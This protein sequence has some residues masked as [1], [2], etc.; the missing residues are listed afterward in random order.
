VIRRFLKDAGFSF[1]GQVVVIVF[2]LASSIII[3]RVLG[4]EQRGV[5]AIV[6]LL[7]MTINAVVA[8]G[9]SATIVHAIA[10]GTW[11][12]SRVMPRVLGIWVYLNLIMLTFGLITLNFHEQLFSG[13]PISLLIFSLALMPASLLHACTGC[14]LA[15]KRAFR[16][17]MYSRVAG[18]PVS[19]LLTIMLVWWLDLSVFGAVTAQLIGIAVS[20][21]L[22]IYWMPKLLCARLM[23]WPEMNPAVLKGSMSFGLKSHIANLS[24]FL[25]YRVDQFLVNG[26][27]GSSAVGIYTVAVNNAERLWLIVGNFA[28][29]LF[30]TASA[31]Q[32]DP[33]AFARFTARLA[34]SMLFVLAIFGALLMLVAEFVIVLLYGED[35]RSAGTLIV[36]LV[37]GIVALGH[38]K[39]LANYVAGQ[40]RPGI[41]AVRGCLALVVNIAANLALIP[42]YGVIGAAVATT[43]SYSLSAFAGYVAFVHVA[44]VR[45]REPLLPPIRD[46]P[47]F[48]GRASRALFGNKAT[49]TVPGSDPTVR[50]PDQQD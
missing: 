13:T 47:G 38:S 29:V 4:P 36:W 7:P 23:F 31:K 40:G 12:D 41:N 25:N 46:L 20:V 16:Y 17:Q 11:E 45:W 48:F 22:D 24:A 18:A 28:Q 21:L 2:A 32:D 3:A 43:I 27:L 6:V 35:F 19:L 26:M 8:S 39:I 9:F 30:P 50:K 49:H 37:P 33:E 42:V 1:V 15:G 10:S 5:L 44:G 34:A 14:I